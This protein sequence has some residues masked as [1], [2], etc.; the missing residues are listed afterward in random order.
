MLNSFGLSSGFLYEEEEIFIDTI[1]PPTHITPGNSISFRINVTNMNSTSILRLT[2]ITM[3]LIKIEGIQFDFE[4]I[5]TKRINH[6][7]QPNS[8]QILDF[9][10]DTDHFIIPDTYQLTISI[11]GKLNNQSYVFG[12][13]SYT[14]K[15]GWGIALILIII[16]LC[17]LPLIGVLYIVRIR[18]KYLKKGRTKRLRCTKCNLRM[19]KDSGLYCNYLDIN[20]KRCLIGP[21][22]SDECFDEHES[23]HSQD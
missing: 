5:R 4:N 12:S 20:E 22:C 2:S 8:S 3:A 6:T 16:L 1:N 18:R 13:Q 14:V 10:F 17:S 9:T 15:V 19:K 21:F 23:E 7:I 11:S